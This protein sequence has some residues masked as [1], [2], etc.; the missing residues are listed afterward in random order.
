MNAMIGT[1]IEEKQRALLKSAIVELE[2]ARTKA[3]VL[4][5][6]LHEPIAIVGM[7][8][9]F[10]GKCDDVKLFWHLLLEGRN[11][12]SPLPQGRIN[13]ESNRNFSEKIY[14]RF[15]NYL[16]HVDKFDRAL[17]RISASEA[18][19]M[20]PQ[21]RLLLEVTWE[22]I[23][24]AGIA[25]EKLRNSLGG[26]YLG[27]MNHDYMYCAM[28]EHN[29]NMHTSAGLGLGL[30]A[31]RLAHNFGF[32]GPSLALDTTCSSS[33]VAL[34]L[35]CHALRRKECNFAIAGG[36]NLILTHHV[37][38][39]T[40]SA[41][42]LASDGRCKTFDEAADGYSRGEGCGVVLLKR[43]TDALAEGDEILA[44]IRGSAVNHDGASSAL[45]V[46]NGIAQEQVILQ[47]LA[48]ARL[49]PDDIGYIEAH[50][51]GTSLGDPIEIEALH[52][53][54]GKSGRNGQPLLVGS[55]KT[56]IGHL[57]GAA[58]IASIIKTV[59]VLRHGVIPSLVNFTQ[60]NPHIPFGSYPFR[61]P[62]EN[63][64][65]PEGTGLR[66]AGVSGFG[67]SGTNA[68]VVLEQAPE[69]LHYTADTTR[70]QH[71]LI[72]SALTANSTR[73]LAARYAQFLMDINGHNVGSICFTAATGRN[74]FDHRLAVV[75]EDA[76]SFRSQLEEYVAGKQPVGVIQGKAPVRQPKVAF[77]FTGEG[78]QYPG[79]GLVLYH[80]HRVFRE[81]L[82]RC[83]A[84]LADHL[85]KPLHSILWGENT[86]FLDNTHYTQPV[87][88]SLEYSLA[89]LWI[90]FGVRPTAVM[91]HGVGEYVAATVAGILS[92]ED[93]L[94]L[95]AARGRLMSEQCLPGRMLSVSAS[96]EKL[97]PLFSGLKD[98]LVIA[99]ENAPEQVLVSGE[100]SA[101]NGLARILSAQKIP[102]HFLRVVQG[103]NSPLMEPF[104]EPFKEVASK[105]NYAEGDI[106]LVS[107]L[108]GKII[109]KN[110]CC[111]SYWAEHARRTVLFN[112]GIEALYG[113][114]CRIFLEVG[115]KATLT[116]LGSRCLG[117][118]DAFWL[119]GLKDEGEQSAPLLKSLGE[120]Y[121][122]G[123]PVD[124]KSVHEGDG[125]LTKV[126]LPT[127]PFER[128]RYWVKET[129][130]APLNQEEERVEY[131]DAAKG[132]LGK[133]LSLAG[134]DIVY[135]ETVLG[136]AHPPYLSDHRVM[137][138]VVMPGA[139]YVCLALEAAC[140]VLGGGSFR[141][142]K[143]TFHRPL[144][145]SKPTRIQTSL[146][147]AQDHQER[148]FEVWSMGTREG[149]W[150]LHASG[151]VRLDQG[152]VV[153]SSMDYVNGSSVSEVSV[154]NYYT[155][156]E[157]QG[158]T[159]GP[160]FRA[161]S[162]IAVA[163]NEA[164]AMISLPEGV[165]DGDDIYFH[166]ILLDAGFQLIGAILEGQIKK[167]QL[168]LPV[169]I[170][171]LLINQPIPSSLRVRI[172]IP[173]LGTSSD[174][175]ECRLEFSTLSG[176]PLVEL[177]GLKLRVVS[178]SDARDDAFLEMESLLYRR[179]WQP[180]PEVVETKPMGAG[181]KNWC[182]LGDA[183]TSDR[184]SK[185]MGSSVGEVYREVV[186]LPGT[187]E[188]V[189]H[190][191]DMSLVWNRCQAGRPVDTEGVSCG[192]IVCLPKARNVRVEE[193]ESQTEGIL[194]GLRALLVSAS[195]SHGTKALTVAVLT[196]E[197]GLMESQESVRLSQSGI[198]GFLRVAS[199]EYPQWHFLQVDLPDAEGDLEFRALVGL[200]LNP[201]QGEPQVVIRNGES[202][203]PRLASTNVQMPNRSFRLNPGGS[204]LVTGGTKGLGL[205]TAAWLV[206]KGA[207]H[208][209]LTGRGQ[210]KGADAE[211]IETL[212]KAGCDVR[213]YSA[214]AGDRA[215]VKNL[216]D[217][218]AKELPAL[219]GVVHSAG[220]LDDGLLKNMAADQWRKVLAP[221]AY[222][223]WYLHELTSTLT[224]DFFV[225][226]SSISSL[227]GNVGQ[228]NY[229]A[230]NAF[231]DALVQ[232]RRSQGL[233]ALGINWGPWS[234]VGM[235]HRSGAMKSMEALGVKGI[236]TERGLAALEVLLG[237]RE[238][239]VAVL[240]MDWKAYAAQWD[241]PPG[242]V[243]KLSSGVRL[244][245]DRSFMME[246]QAAVDFVSLPR[247]TALLKI[248]DYMRE[249][250]IAVTAMDSAQLETATQSFTESQLS[251]L[252]LDSLKAMELRDRF[253]VDLK[254]V[255]PLQNLLG[256]RKV[257]DIVMAIYEGS[258]LNCLNSR[259][260]TLA[261]TVTP[262]AI[263][264]ETVIL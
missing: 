205:A 238:A 186:A 33:L 151:R 243:R 245:A 204:F 102:S 6:Q 146:K 63:T 224:L 112:S 214:D 264:I 46:P 99:A 203:V 49:K 160:S 76:A 106:P 157:E 212:R 24:N 192:V 234:E 253:K 11:T 189:S 5:R 57:E 233:P 139:A 188:S 115:P 169:G 109:G 260:G 19:Q 232:Q 119:A 225:V 4:E 227:L 142:T 135:Y 156:M 18:E 98:R 209:A 42:M 180:L 16:D 38:L 21:H 118:K 36:V 62:L 258:L 20:D 114:G 55:V 104:L 81:N 59:L 199:L 261:E 41:K 3:E 263:E 249:Q 222:G 220:V 141:L 30:A 177:R 97:L 52:K 92:L 60:L 210:P 68:H 165:R 206:S 56:N 181:K 120:C 54:F 37:D 94:K 75:G 262:N 174:S 83:A 66:R 159:Y 140:S 138:D 130:D 103:F 17:F 231:L 134:S 121:V 9:R 107:N 256:D 236:P 34:H 50:G 184:V 246:R 251:E 132:F 90:Y 72:L 147:S 131:P 35:A 201:P 255:L 65:W 143:V 32:R 230:A 241:C 128:Q 113:H 80:S 137:G 198:A 193:L 254:I 172:A 163:G 202:M 161:L 176:S 185:A 88:F 136:A 27:I 194:D 211:K 125:P 13:A 133:R 105:I 124:W 28:K 85:D 150:Q 127:Y 218:I 154:N 100:E 259:T 84:I 250:V 31:G 155:W 153:R 164:S 69:P 14:S 79:M 226:Y 101:I 219:R 228:A 15:G 108:T 116:E 175:M 215:M 39:V 110:E 158:L 77:L 257:S 78:C 43:L 61:L 122:R 74:H 129:A 196:R 86:G 91:G 247:E 93:G 149:K 64:P 207:R 44:T 29:I 248:S 179:S 152:A 95:I 58:G 123:V 191:D 23:E 216:I 89:A 252:G 71:L 144:L 8:C 82:D 26:V 12:A 239:Q 182:I 48:D 117:A 197:T 223:A 67:L 195:K 171:E 45:P 87:L 96:A 7:A 168:F 170:E 242:L 190:Y 51:T 126:A 25:A 22:A 200:L 167:G 183:E 235:A 240:S 2:K 208:L 213:V 187:M 244:D 73:E 148:L 217:K 173:Q 111:P 221:K 162:D 40:C 145:L 70:R 10:P 47:A 166:T 178:E 53:V 1:G 229:A 237:G